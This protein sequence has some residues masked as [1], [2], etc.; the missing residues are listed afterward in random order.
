[1]N[2][3]S[4]SPLVQ[5]SRIS[6]N[7]SER[8]GAISKITIH[9]MAG[10]MTANG[11]L[12]W[13]SRSST[14]ASSNYVIGYD[15]TIG[16]SVPEE[17]RSWCS[18]SRANDNVAVTIELSN[19]S[20]GGNWP[21]SDKVI[22]RCIELCVD[23]CQ[24]NGIKKLVY[25]GDTSGNLTR[26]DMFVSKVCPGPYLGAKFPYIVEEVNKRLGNEIVTTGKPT[27]RYGDENDYVRELQKDLIKLGYEL[28]GYK[29]TGYF[30]SATDKDVRRFQ[31]DHDL[32]VDGVV[33]P[34]TWAAIDS[35]LAELQEE[36]PKNPDEE[37][38]P[39]LIRIIKE[40]PVSSSKPYM[41]LVEG[42]YTIMEEA[43]G[44]GRLKSGAGWIPL[45]YVEKV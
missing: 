42:D 23:I 39:Y 32:D 31:A 40:T 38:F 24:R 43:N 2:S 33:G 22:D 5:V 18:S 29:P 41:T 27:L 26:H 21:V 44:S 13:F 19:S 6:P 35:K 34:I 14:Q 7:K 1:M 10:V 25:T 16:L 28:G 45:D 20:T 8:G 4:N 3:L 11:C 17:Y 15:G 37:K 12:D 9:H 36:E 30:G